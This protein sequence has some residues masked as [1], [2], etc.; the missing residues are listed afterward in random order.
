MLTPTYLAMYARLGVLKL[1]LRGRLEL[2]GIAFV[3]PGVKFEVGKGAVVRLGRWAWIGGECRLRVHEGRFELGAK[4]VLG[5]QCTITA[6]QN[7]TIGR[8]CVIA[9][10]VMLID[11]DHC[12]ADVERPIRRQGIYKRDVRIGHN[13]WVGYGVCVL[14]G[15]TVGDNAVLG[16]GAVVTQNVPANAVA[17]GV[18][19]RVLR[20]RD[21]PETLDWDG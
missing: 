11:F 8:E 12:A 18:P 21:T 10:R 19:A 20:M 17:G 3:H 14:R 4:S 15:V 7:V 5:Q 2:D 13:C 9:D 6:F 1:R 16:A